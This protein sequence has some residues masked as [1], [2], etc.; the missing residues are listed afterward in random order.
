MGNQMANNFFSMLNFAQLMKD[1]FTILGRRL[2][3]SNLKDIA[4]IEDAQ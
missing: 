1:N 4:G 3:S 2:H